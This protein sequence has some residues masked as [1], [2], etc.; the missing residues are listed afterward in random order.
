M[1]NSFQL[2]NLLEY[3]N[4]TIQCH[5]FPDADTIASAFALYVFLTERG[6]GAR[7]IYSG[8]G[9][10]TKPNLTRMIEVFAI[11]IEYIHREGLSVA[12]TL[13]MMDCQYGES[14]AV[15]IEANNIFIID[16]HEDNGNQYPGVIKSGL[17]SCATLMWGLLKE[18][19]FDFEKHPNVSSALYYGL[20]TDTNNFEEIG[21]PLDKDMRDGVRFDPT[22]IDD[23]R[24]N[25]LTMDELN[26]A[27]IALSRTK[28]N[29]EHGFSIIKSGPCDQN[30]LGF[31]SDLAM[32]VE[33]VGVCI[34]YNELPGGYKLSIRSC[35]REVMANEFATFLANGGGHKRK[36]GGFI[37]KDKIGCMDIDD[38]IESRTNAYYEDYDVLYSNNHN[39]AITDAPKYI[40]RKIPVGYVKTTDVFKAGTPILIRTLEGDSDTEASSNIY[41]MIGIKGEAYPIAADKFAASYEVSDE[42][43]DG[44]FEYS[45]TVKNKI[46][47]ESVQVRNYAKACVPTSVVPIYAIPLTQNTKVFSDWYPM[48]YM[49]GKPGDYLAAR[50][51]DPNEL[52]IIRDDIF[53][54]TYDSMITFKGCHSSC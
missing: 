43:F 24:F 30:I 8:T 27:G 53:H 2:R 46:T 41:I 10:I 20:Y 14:N 11:P 7:I 23:L 40:K 28:L 12:N 39:I 35:I 3:E 1:N 52:Y 42:S 4:L 26:V 17:G 18:E 29:H 38:Y 31:I 22:I 48:G 45:P 36:A 47:G 21:H 49:R 44:V 34:V 5:N 13:V 6:K 19:G 15:K 32:Q 25:N 50:V 51:D 54:K 16:H 33:N 37:P 9:K